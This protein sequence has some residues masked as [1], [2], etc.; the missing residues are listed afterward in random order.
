MN[1]SLTCR[2]IVVLSCAT[3]LGSST[4]N[5]DSCADW[6]AASKIKL[7]KDCLVK[8]VVAPVDMATFDC[9]NA[10]S[11][12]CSETVGTDF[13]FKLSELY[14]GLSDAERA[15]VST[16]PK[17][18]LRAYVAKGRAESFCAIQFVDN[19]TNDES[20]ACRHFFWASFLRNDLGENLALKFLNAHEEHPSQPEPEKHMDIANNRLGLVAAERLIKKNG[21]SETA[22]LK[23]FATALTQKKVI[24]LKPQAKD[25]KPK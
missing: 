4:A 7:G 17:A 1:P 15:L 11:M 3:I 9:H 24:V 22:L 21:L 6:F 12:L 23:E 8:C 2:F 16:N 20:D 25:W 14:P 18:A 19:R 13:I 10:C 5:A